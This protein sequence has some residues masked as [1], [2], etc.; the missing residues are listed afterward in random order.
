MNWLGALADIEDLEDAEFDAARPAE[1][2]A[3][4]T[5]LRAASKYRNGG[6]VWTVLGLIGWY[7]IESNGYDKQLYV[8]AGGFA[9][10]GLLHFITPLYA[11]LAGLMGLYLGWLYEATGNLIVP[12]IVHGLYD[13]AA[14]VYLVRIRRPEREKRSGKEGMQ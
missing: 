14:L 11:L 1:H 3:A 9:V 4:D 8:L 7:L 13:F 5:T 12:M 2:V 10:F 6:I